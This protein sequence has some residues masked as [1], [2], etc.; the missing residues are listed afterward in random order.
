MATGVNPNPFPS[1]AERQLTSLLD[2]PEPFGGQ[3]CAP[4][5]F[6]CRDRALQFLEGDFLLIPSMGQNGIGRSLGV[7]EG[8]KAQLFRMQQPH[9]G[10]L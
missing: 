8:L 5:H 9:V 4:Y 7:V 10:D 6:E 1:I 2:L 3:L